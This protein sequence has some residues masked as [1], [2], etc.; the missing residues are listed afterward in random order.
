[1]AT[2]PSI[3]RYALTENFGPARYRLY[4]KRHH[5][6][7][8]S[9]RCPRYTNGYG[10]VVLLASSRRP[11]WDR[12]TRGMTSSVSFRLD[13]ETGRVASGAPSQGLAHDALAMQFE[14]GS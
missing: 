7:V 10:H 6:A 8:R 3:L 9:A 1:V 11:R 12:R 5:G 13:V 2:T 14:I 4:D